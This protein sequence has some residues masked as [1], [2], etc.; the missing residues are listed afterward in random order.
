[1][2]LN[3][4]IKKSIHSQKDHFKIGNIL[5]II[6]ITLYFVLT[7]KTVRIELG[8]LHFT[9]VTLILHLL[10]LMKPGFYFNFFVKIC[11]RNNSV[12]I[13]T[14][15]SIIIDYVISLLENCDNYI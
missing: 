12:K 1:M 15:Q 10:V 7:L 6:G 9:F 4:K 2:L 14:G 8:G 5:K 3:Q 11:K 13:I